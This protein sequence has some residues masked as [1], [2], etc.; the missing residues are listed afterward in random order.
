MEAG[1]TRED[2]IKD[3]IRYLRH[4]R[5]ALRLAEAPRAAERV[6]LALTSARGA[7]RHARRFPDGRAGYGPLRRI[8]RTRSSAR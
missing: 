3:A 6:R 7:L 2:Y 1:M 5:I 8:S 4:A